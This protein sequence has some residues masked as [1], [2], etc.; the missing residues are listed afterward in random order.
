MLFCFKG[1]CKGIFQ[2]RV[3]RL[4][5]EVHHGYTRNYSRELPQI[6]MGFCGITHKTQLQVLVESGTPSGFKL[7]EDARAQIL[8][9]Q[10]AAKVHVVAPVSTANVVL[11]YSAEFQQCLHCNSAR[12]SLPVPCQNPIRGATFRSDSFQL[13]KW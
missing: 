6:R 7:I 4:V 12:M 8:E 2:S 11:H 13:V 3:R 1:Y 5:M 10:E 9:Q